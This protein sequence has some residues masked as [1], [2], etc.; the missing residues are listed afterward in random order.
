MYIYIYIIYVYFNT[1]SWLCYIYIYAYI[2]KYIEAI[3]KLRRIN[4][5]REEKREDETNKKK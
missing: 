2:L 3:M 1:L 4:I 5:R